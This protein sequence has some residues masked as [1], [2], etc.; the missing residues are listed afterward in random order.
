VL[1]NDV[2]PVRHRNSAIPKPLAK[3][4]DLALVD[5]PEAY[6]KSAGEFKQALLKNYLGSHQTGWR[7]GYR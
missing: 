4:I 2:I 5:N 7:L 3:V 6:F 1:Q